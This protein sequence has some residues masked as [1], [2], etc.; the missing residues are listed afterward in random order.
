MKHNLHRSMI[1]LLLVAL[2]LGAP[3]GAVPAMA[4]SGNVWQVLYYNN[5]NWAG[6]PVNTQAASMVSFNWGSDTSPA[7]YVP[8]QNWSARFT[9][10][11]FFYAGLYRFQ[12]QADDAFVLY[13]DGVI[14]MNTVGTGQAGKA[15]TIDIPLTQTSHNV[16]LDFVQYTGAAYVFLNWSLVKGGNPQPA[17]TPPPSSGPNQPFPPPSS[18]VTQF[19]DYTSCAQQQIHQKN[20]F[21]SN[22]AWNAPNMGSI[23]MEPQII[24]WQQCTADQMASVQ[25]YTNQPPQSAKCSK[26]EA[27][28]F[29][30]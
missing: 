22:G 12:I 2:C 3:L 8:P 23:E 7:P 19:G 24:R 9:T 29:P 20:C 30:A 10:T 27:G 21:Q 17:P 28:W 18:L 16:Q 5:P 14:Y 11:A 15:F 4:Q 6:A 13:V 26:T 1:A 25:L